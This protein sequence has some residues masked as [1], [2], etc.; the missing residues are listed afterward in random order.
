MTVRRL[1]KEINIPDWAVDLT[2]TRLSP[3]ST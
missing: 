1:R 2:R 3:T